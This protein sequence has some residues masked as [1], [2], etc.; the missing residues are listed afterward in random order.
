MKGLNTK[1]KGTKRWRALELADHGA[2]WLLTGRNY[3]YL[4]IYIYNNKKKTLCKSTPDDVRPITTVFCVLPRNAFGNWDDR[5][6]VGKILQ[7][8]YLESV[9]GTSTW[10]VQERGK[11]ELK[12]KQ[13]K[14]S[15]SPKNNKKAKEAIWKQDWGNVD[16]IPLFHLQSSSPSSSCKDRERQLMR[17]FFNLEAVLT[18]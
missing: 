6:H 13:K 16:N 7:S 9:R 3:T 1:N 11:M 15:C 10:Q 4:Y 5:C 14:A 2:P 12:N 8:V 17:D 18:T